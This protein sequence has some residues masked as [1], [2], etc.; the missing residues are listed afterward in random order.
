M[1][2]THVYINYDHI[3]WSS[4][5][6]TYPEKMLDKQKMASKYFS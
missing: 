3:L 1:K 2:L 5:S 6:K 4:N